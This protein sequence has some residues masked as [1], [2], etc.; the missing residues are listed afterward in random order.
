MPSLCQVV[1]ETTLRML[2]KCCALIN[3]HLEILRCHYLGY[4][5]LALLQCK[6]LVRLAK[7]SEEMLNIRVVHWTNHV[8]PAKKKEDRQQTNY[9]LFGP[10]QFRP[11]ADSPTHRGRLAPGLF[12]PVRGI[13]AIRRQKV[14]AYN[15]LAVKRNCG[16]RM[17]IYSTLCVD[18]PAHS[19]S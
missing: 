8:R 16:F 15:L 11:L 3:H 10:L 1:E 18:V 4:E 7:A 12:A 14:Y 5:E 13:I 9:G 17:C 6:P 2:R 19:L